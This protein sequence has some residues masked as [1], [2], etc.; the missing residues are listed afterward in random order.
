MPTL[1]IKTVTEHNKKNNVALVATVFLIF[2]LLTTVGFNLVYDLI[3]KNKVYSQIMIGDWDLGGQSSQV[4]LDILEQKTGTLKN[5]GFSLQVNNEK[6]ITILPIVS[7]LSDPDLSYELISF[8]N[9][10]TID[11]AYNQGRSNNLITN[12]LFKI[13]SLFVPTPITLIYQ[14]DRQKL[15]TI[16]RSSLESQKKPAQNATIKFIGDEI[17]ILPEEQGTIFDYE[18]VLKEIELRLKNLTNQPINILAQVDLPKVKQQEAQ[19]L[20]PAIKQIMNT[21]TPVLYFNTAADGQKEKKL[22]W[23]ISLAEIKKWLVFD[24]LDSNDVIL[25]FNSELAIDFFTPISQEVNLPVQEAKFEVNNGRVTKFQTSR[26]GRE[27]DLEKTLEKLRHDYLISNKKEVELVI[28][29]TKSKITTVSD[30]NDLGISEIIGIGR[31]NFA[32]SPKNRRHNIKTGAESINGLLIKPEE[33]FSL[34]KA[35][36][37]IDAST[38]YLPELVIKGD[39]T[40]PEYGGGLCQIG[41]T[42]FR[43]ALD[44]GLPITERKNHSYRVR[45]YEPAGTDATIYSPHPDLRFMNDTK[46]YLLLQT[47]IE[48]DDLIFELWGQNDGRHATTTPSK[49]YNFIAPPPSKTIETEDLKPGE[50]KCTEHAITGATAEF[51]YTINYPD[52]RKIENIFKSVYRPW[53][54]VCLIGIDPTKKVA[55][56]T[57]ETIP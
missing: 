49:I 30:I 38:G 11:H 28:K 24:K 39:R 26:D 12:Y 8:Q 31:S 48:G 45:Y 27:L 9:K 25:N 32:G 41:T 2:F 51:T 20:I 40:I 1:K 36:G 22:T 44:S 35:L 10:E 56:T 4:A 19:N 37:N 23:A 53:Q 14:I 16:I 3:F 52:G 18:Q 42:M 33:E 21:S 55:T 47:K 6:K 13:K 46:N 17:V 29:S 57:S 7:S 54:E 34:N 5:N 43:A 15:L 50:K